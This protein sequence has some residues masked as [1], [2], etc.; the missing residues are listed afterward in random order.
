MRI[1][2]SFLV[3]FARESHK[4]ESFLWLERN[5][6]P[7]LFEVLQREVEPVKKDGFWQQKPSFY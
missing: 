4:N 6:C 5:D 1:L 2:W 7:D 3:L